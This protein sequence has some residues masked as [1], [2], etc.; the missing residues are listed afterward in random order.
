MDKETRQTANANN[1]IVS[2]NC[3]GI[4]LDKELKS[5]QLTYNVE[6]DAEDKAEEK[7]EGSYSSKTGKGKGKK[8]QSSG[9]S[10]NKKKTSVK[11]AARDGKFLKDVKQI[12]CYPKC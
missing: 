5:F 8:G 6:G 10:S 3:A 11:V 9:K 1:V 2:R 12:L 4:R 7:K